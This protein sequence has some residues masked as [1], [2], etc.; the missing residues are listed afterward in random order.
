MSNH[1]Y[2]QRVIKTYNN[3]TCEF[4]E[5][6]PVCQMHR[7]DFELLFGVPTDVDKVWRVRDYEQNLRNEERRKNFECG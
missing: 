3:F 6:V 2:T 4:D 7:Y 5:S 1:G